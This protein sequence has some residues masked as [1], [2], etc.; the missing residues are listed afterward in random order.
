M[1]WSPSIRMSEIL[2]RLAAG[3]GRAAGGGAGRGIGLATGR[4]AMGT[5]AAAGGATGGGGGASGGGAGGGGATKFWAMAGRSHATA[6]T[7]AATGVS[8]RFLTRV[9]RKTPPQDAILSRDR[10]K[11]QV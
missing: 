11:L 2:P 5:G 7:A 8:Q 6:K 1:P 9:C 3:P 10:P 4:G